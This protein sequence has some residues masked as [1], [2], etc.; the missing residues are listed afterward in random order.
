MSKQIIRKVYNRTDQ[1]RQ[2]NFLRSVRILYIPVQEF[3]KAYKLLTDLEFLDI[4]CNHSKYGIRELISDYEQLIKY[5]QQL[6]SWEK[7]Q[8]EILQILRDALVLSVDILEKNPDQLVAQ[9]LGRLMYFT[10]PEIVRLVQQVENH[11]APYLVP[12]NSVL[13][14][15]RQKLIRTLQGHEGSEV[16]A[17]IT[18]PFT[19]E[20]E[21]SFL[22]VS[23]GEDRRIKVWDGLSGNLYQ[24]LENHK[25]SITA[26]T[27]TQDGKYIFSGSADGVV[28]IWQ[29]NLID[30]QKIEIKPL[31]S[32]VLSHN[33]SVKALAISADQKLLLVASGQ[34][35]YVYE[36]QS[37]HLVV[38]LKGHTGVINCLLCDRANQNLYSGSDD[39][40]IYIWDI[41]NY[42]HIG[43]LK[44]KPE[45][46]ESYRQR[47]ASKLNSVLS[48]CFI[49]QTKIVGIFRDGLIHEFD[50]IKKQETRNHSLPSIVSYK[51]FYNIANGYICSFSRYES[52]NSLAI[53]AENSFTIDE[54][55]EIF[56]IFRDDKAK[57]YNSVHN[58]IV[59]T[60]CVSP[61]NEYAISGE[62]E[63]KIWR[64]SNAIE[65][66]IIVTPAHNK[67][68]THIEIA[69]DKNICISASDGFLRV[70]NLSTLEELW[71][72]RI[73][74]L[75]DIVVSMKHESNDVFAV[76][77]KDQFVIFN[78]DDG[79]VI[80]WEELDSSYKRIFFTMNWNIQSL[81]TTIACNEGFVF[82]IINHGQPE[83]IGRGKYSNQLTALAVSSLQ[84]AFGS[85]SIIQI[86]D[87]QSNKV[88]ICLSDQVKPKSL[89][90][91]YYDHRLLTWLSDDSIVIYDG[92]IDEKNLEKNLDN[93]SSIF[94]TKGRGYQLLNSEEYIIP[95]SKERIMAAIYRQDEHNSRES[96]IDVIDLEFCEVRCR[97]MVDVPSL[98]SWQ[99]DVD[100]D[101]NDRYLI[102]IYDDS[103]S[104]SVS[105]LLVAKNL[106]VW[107]LWRKKKCC[108]FVN[109]L[110]ITSY[111]MSSKLKSIIVGDAGGRLHFLQF[112]SEDT[113]SINLYLNRILS[114]KYLEYLAALK[115]G[116]IESTKSHLNDSENQ[117]EYQ[118]AL[119]G[120]IDPDSPEI[121]TLIEKYYN[122]QEIDMESCSSFF[123]S[124]FY[125]IKF[126][127]P[128]VIEHIKTVRKNMIFLSH[129]TEMFEE[130][131]L[132][133]AEI[134]ISY[135]P[136]NYEAYWI[137]GKYYLK[138]AKSFFEE[139]LYKQG[140]QAVE[141]ASASLD[142]ANLLSK[143]S[144]K[145]NNTIFRS[146]DE[147]DA[148]ELK[149]FFWQPITNIAES[150]D[151]PL[152][153]ETD[154]RAALKITNGMISLIESSEYADIP[155]LLARAYMYKAKLNLML[156]SNI[157][158]LEACDLVMKNNPN[159]S[160][161]IQIYKIMTEIYRR[162][163]NIELPTNYSQLD[164]T[165]QQHLKSIDKNNMSKYW[166]AWRNQYSYTVW[167]SLWSWGDQWEN[168]KYM[169]D[170]LKFFMLKII[171]PIRVF[172]Y[173][174]IPIAVLIYFIYSMTNL[175]TMIYEYIC[176]F[177][178]SL[179]KK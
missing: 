10:Q 46:K 93:I 152:E 127:F 48:M 167:E 143:S 170:R 7:K 96:V 69:P 126:D 62:K 171:T 2:E 55:K 26:L 147:A 19:Q 81:T 51:N 53:I 149:C 117:S 4:K 70:W 91:V 115:S 34:K 36:W 58:N 40:L 121:L 144:S 101:T 92:L 155:D 83:L 18:T 6:E 14:A 54:S 44:P 118:K 107:D 109:D 57:I 85:D 110:E 49:D 72:K 122:I 160:T 151:F 59:S 47:M 129:M 29:V 82:T 148:L 103:L 80:L 21:Q 106:V 165:F 43:T 63:I 86:F 131:N 154:I 99:F 128:K 145:V 50:I 61:D 162:Q 124:I 11:P 89:A 140:L 42:R 138:Q 76:T 13:P 150:Y 22:I 169:D 153:T 71:D 64:V 173:Y 176:Y 166:W 137:K 41:Q 24:T 68:I 88:S 114:S 38:I 65:N 98:V 111:R 12:R 28:I 16:T 1:E 156:G 146:A 134:I 135:D 108:E 77:S 17:L 119:K 112:K 15:P 142:K 125:L 79:K 130:E 3:Q 60:F 78:T 95:I 39:G 123:K 5:V 175:I 31:H 172:L 35:I 87:I 9:L 132:K 104:K 30:E 139:K 102:G 52:D 100:F 178:G 177:L 25:D 74:H 158:A 159:G 75:Q 133:N 8:T 141:M 32:E 157:E 73:H 136:N 37:N 105:T 20:F 120:I 116:D 94:K 163:N 164:K 168:N 56:K 33:D 113:E 97:I 66:E 161:I 179:N 84:V 67:P 23:G 27:S 90:F 45:L 174:A